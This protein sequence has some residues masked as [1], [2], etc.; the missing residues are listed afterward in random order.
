M[1]IRIRLLP[2]L[3]S[4]SLP[5][6][7]ACQVLAPAAQ[8]Q[9][10]LFVDR[11]SATAVP[12]APIVPPSTR[13]QIDTTYTVTRGTIHD[14]VA[15]A[16]KVAPARSAQLNFASAGTVTAVF[17]HS[18]ES[19]TQGEPLAEL[20]LSKE[21][22]DLAQHQSLIAQ[23]TYESQAAKVKDLQAG[24]L[25]GA[26]ADAQAAVARTAAAQREAELKTPV[27]SPAA[28]PDSTVG[29]AQLD[30]DQAQRDL[31]QATQAR[32][33]KATDSAARVT[34]TSALT[35]A[36]ERRV[37]DAS[38]KL[39]QLTAAQAAAGA[40]HEQDVQL[41]GVD[42]RQATSDLQTAQQ[43]E[44]RVRRQIPDEMQRAVHLAELDLQ[45]AN[46]ALRETQDADQRLNAEGPTAGR[47][48]EAILADIVRVEWTVQAAK[49]SVSSATIKLDQA[50]AALVSTPEMAIASAQAAV[51]TAQ[52]H[53]NTASI[54]VDQARTSA[55]TAAD[56]QAL[57]QAR[58]A[59][60][61]ATDD[62]A[63]ARTAEQL[64]RSDLDAVQ[65][66]VPADGQDASVEDAAVGAAE[67]RASAA[68][69]KLTQAQAAQA[70]QTTTQAAAQRDAVAQNQVANLDLR[71]KQADSA[72]AAAHL[73]DLQAGSS[74][75]AIDREARLADLLR[76][77]ADQT[78]LAAQAVVTLRA[79]FDGLV[80]AVAVSQGQAID[81][82]ATVVRFAGNDG[83][84]VIATASETEVSQ[85]TADQQVDVTFPN[86]PDLTARG[87]IVDISG[88]GSTLDG[89]KTTSFPV[90]VDLATAPSQLK[91]GMA[92]LLSVS[93]REA[94][95]VLYL[96]ANTIRQSNGTSLV[97][98]LET[99]GK[100]TDVPIQIGSTYGSDVEITGGLTEGDV[101]AV[102]RTGGTTVA[103][104]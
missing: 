25:P 40:T 24:A 31:N 93:L 104:Q 20:Q 29:L 87:T 30:V 81:P 57:Q 47:T 18:G 62:L 48:H 53:V 3:A 14:A 74:S 94:P 100:V 90:R 35:R 102:F 58:T 86:L 37:G 21:S 23:L 13:S 1:K 85:L 96:P 16:G 98:R 45:E 80:A 101:V 49:N 65:A 79:P 51:A 26:L 39:D 70:V 28:A 44:A 69:L 22:L 66:T 63:Q 77:E 72:A 84:T 89:G 92:A 27:G 38:S 34:A 10:Q 6:M 4:L 12:N 11:G 59:V 8:P 91:I 82:R 83:L 75:D 103:N 73:A 41:A 71:V 42:L 7:S 97:S 19:A 95:N 61:Q 2:I 33:Q 76:D 99:D 60:Q 68:A 88:V 17:V 55:T 32:D 15:V 67:G 52:S 43:A 78:R 9:P 36:A 56:D 50:R 46:R 5:L 54:K 64:A